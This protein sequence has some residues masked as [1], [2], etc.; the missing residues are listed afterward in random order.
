MTHLLLFSIHFI[1]YLCIF[2]KSKLQL[3]FHGYELHSLYNV[4]AAA[5][6]PGW[7]HWRLSV[8]HTVEDES[9]SP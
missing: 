5:K 4:D 6:E 3:Y 9:N 1:I 2:Q 7:S 8:W